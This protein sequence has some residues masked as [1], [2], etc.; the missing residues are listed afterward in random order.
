MNRFRALVPTLALVL[1]LPLA[2]QDRPAPHSA[3][4]PAPTGAPRADVQPSIRAFWAGLGVALGTPGFGVQIDA[5]LRNDGR[6]MRGRLLVLDGGRDTDGQIL[7]VTELAGMYG[8]GRRLGYMRNWYSASA[9]LALLTGERNGEEFTTIGIPL[10][11]QAVSRRVPHL[12]AAL[13]ANL[14]PEL[15]FVA[16]TMS[17]QLG[18]A[19]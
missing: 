14:N 3:A 2:A 4:E 7:A 18:R 6:V 13:T 16:A 12:G 15:P 11:L 17:L 8:V 1:T 10:E 5:T 19:P 9:G